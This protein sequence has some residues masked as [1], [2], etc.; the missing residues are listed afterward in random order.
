MN[1]NIILVA[2]IVVA[3]AGAGLLY[4]NS[5]KEAAD[6][7]DI[8]KNN[9]GTAQTAENNNAAGQTT[10]SSINEL[11]ASAVPT[12]CTYSN[13]IDSG[14]G[15]TMSG[16]IYAAGGQARTD[17]EI[18]MTGQQKMKMHAILKDGYEYIWYDEGPMAGTGMK[19]DINKLKAA[20]KTQAAEQ[21]SV[22]TE[23]KMDMVCVPWSAEGTAFDTP[24]GIDFKDITAVTTQ[25]IQN[26]PQSACDACKMMPDAQTQEQCRKANNCDAQ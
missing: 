16:S 3:I 7:T 18:S 9:S 5:Q 12:K 19:L 24:A 8:A 11:L 1:K 4:F 23:K 6:N 17:M 13:A 14:E 21:Q 10:A 2:V 22:D 26:A 15:G 25:T 20:T